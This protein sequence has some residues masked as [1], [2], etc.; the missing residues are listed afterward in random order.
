MAN[1]A[2]ARYLKWHKIPIVYRV[3]EKPTE[4]RLKNVRTF[5][6]DFGLTLEGGDEPTAHDYATVM[7]KNQ[8]ANL[9]SI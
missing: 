6:K 9:M 3:H 5:L 4:E 8:K 2:T 7:E 1:V